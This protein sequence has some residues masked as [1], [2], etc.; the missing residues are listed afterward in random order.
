MAKHTAN[1]FEW[2]RRRRIIN[3]TLGFCLITAGALLVAAVGGQD[4]QLLQTLALCTFGLAGSTIGS[5]VFGAV[6]DD[7][8]ARDALPKE[9]STE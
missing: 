9:D 8:N 3:L 5:Y 6:W 2:K 7:K 1:N 4:T